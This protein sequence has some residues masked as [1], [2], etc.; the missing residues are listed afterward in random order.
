MI[1][2]S[3]KNLRKAY[4]ENVVIADLSFSVEKG[5]KVALSAPSGYGKTTLF[6]LIS[7]LEKP[8]AGQIFLSSPAAY[9][10]QEPR[11]FPHLTVR[12][13][14]EAVLSGKDKRKRAEAWLTTVGLQSAA[15]IGKYPDEISGGMA[16]RVVLARALAA[17]RDI[18][19]L[20]EPFKGLDKESVAELI[21]LLLQ[22]TADKTLLLIT[23]DEEEARALCD[24]QLRF[25]AGMRLDADHRIDK[26]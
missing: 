5:E 9:I 16:Q 14:V 25:S 1:A 4:D 3:I 20:D 10:F 15:D 2:L 24:R 7:G 18:L 22:T 23:H 17:G 13:N 19:L 21:E 11:L 8:D 12:E 26:K 6:R